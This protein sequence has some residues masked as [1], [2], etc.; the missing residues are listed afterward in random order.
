MT[1][2][3]D[4]GHTLSIPTDHLTS[5]AELVALI[6]TAI[7][8]HV[9]LVSSDLLHGDRQLRLIILNQIVEEAAHKFMLLLVGQ[10]G[11]CS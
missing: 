8:E 9:F 2:L 11:P 5:E 7:V 3:F 1:H 10:V 4:E 6:R